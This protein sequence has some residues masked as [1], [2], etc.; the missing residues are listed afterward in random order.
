MQTTKPLSAWPSQCV[1]GGLGSWIIIK[2]L[3][4]VHGIRTKRVRNHTFNGV[5]LRPPVSSHLL[6]RNGSAKWEWNTQSLQYFRLT[7]KYWKWL[8]DRPWKVWMIMRI[9]F[10][11]IL[12]PPFL[13][14]PPFPPLFSPSLYLLSSFFFLWLCISVTCFYTKLAANVDQET[15]LIL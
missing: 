2:D 14:P 4:E 10:S 12:S 8:L 11:T 9:F 7:P 1:P 5:R 13:F 6:Q 3:H 15:S